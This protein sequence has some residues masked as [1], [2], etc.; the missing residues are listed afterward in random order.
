MNIYLTLIKYEWYAAIRSPMWAKNLISLIVSFLG[1]AMFL[2]IVPMSGYYF[3]DILFAIRPGAIPYMTV[4]GYLPQYFITTTVFLAMSLNASSDIPTLYLIMPKMRGK[5]VRYL[6]SKSLLHGLQR[7]FILFFV[8][9]AWHYILPEYGLLK[10]LFVIFGYFQIHLITTLLV[11]LL[12]NMAIKSWLISLG[13]VVVLIALTVLN[14]LGYLD[15]EAIGWYAMEKLVSINIV[16][17]ATVLLTFI[18][19][20]EKNFTILSQSFT[21]DF[22]GTKKR[23]KEGWFS[24]LFLNK[25]PIS[26][27]YLFRLIGYDNFKRPSFII[28]LLAHSIFMGLFVFVPTMF[29]NTLNMLMYFQMLASSLVVNVLPSFFAFSSSYMDGLATRK[30]NLAQLLI[31]HYRM[32]IGIYFIMLICWLPLLY[33]KTDSVALVLALSLF[34]AGFTACVYMLNA[35]FFAGRVELGN[36]KRNAGGSKLMGG[37]IVAL[38]GVWGLTMFL[39][40][41]IGTVLGKPT[42]LVIMGSMGFLFIATHSIWLKEIMLHFDKNKYQKLTTYRAK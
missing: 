22:T 9:F 38:L 37:S 26:W 18:L 24:D 13:A 20:M 8:P 32:I 5:V 29:A 11:L 17:H 39:Y 21:A 40:A 30:I 35:Y 3:G 36:K 15:T 23:E 16:F 28:A 2:I 27:L 7:L 19:L 6:L 31:L 12:K 33:L 42:A 14:K 25:L 34:H 10:T 4:A 41:V 1:F